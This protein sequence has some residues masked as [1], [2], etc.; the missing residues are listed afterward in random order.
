M[1]YEAGTIDAQLVEFL[2]GKVRMEFAEGVRLAEISKVRV[3]G[4][5]GVLTGQPR[6]TRVVT[7]DASTVL[8]LE[9][10]NLE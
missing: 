3:I 5:M 2:Q 9:V 7:E 4:E 6:S 10:A 1:L 8:E